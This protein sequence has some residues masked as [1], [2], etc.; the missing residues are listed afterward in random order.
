[1]L[2]NLPRSI[3]PISNERESNGILRCLLLSQVGLVC[4]VGFDLNTL[5]PLLDSHLIS[6]MQTVAFARV[7]FLPQGHW[8]RPE[9]GIVERID[10]QEPSLTVPSRC[11][12]LHA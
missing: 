2:T 12:A 7:A 4:Y 1:M 9:W 3:S 11:N 6:C 5:S 8:R 10:G